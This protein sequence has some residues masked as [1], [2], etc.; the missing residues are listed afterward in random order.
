MQSVS[1]DIVQRHREAAAGRHGEGRDTEKQK[2]VAGRDQFKKKV[3]S[4]EERNG[5]GKKTIL[6][7]NMN[8]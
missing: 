1:M 8:K 6:E 3:V 5:Q 7:G 2:I 4:A